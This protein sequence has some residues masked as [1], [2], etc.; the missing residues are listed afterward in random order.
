MTPR[1]S[2]RW[3]HAV[4][5]PEVVPSEMRVETDRAVRPTIP[6]LFRTTAFAYKLY[7]RVADPRYIRTGRRDW[8]L[9]AAARYREVLASGVRSLVPG[10]WDNPTRTN[11]QRWLSMGMGESSIL[12]NSSQYRHIPQLL[13]TYGKLLFV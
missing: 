3:T 11:L 13:S 10:R 5:L 9:I 7:L 12:E 1:G 4:K 6:T 2:L 8:Y